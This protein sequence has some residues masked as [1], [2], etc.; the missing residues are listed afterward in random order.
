MDHV[1]IDNDVMLD[2]LLNRQPFSDDAAKIYELCKTGVI[3]GYTSPVILSNAHYVLR[4]IHSHENIVKSF[5]KLL[6]VIDLVEINKI[7]VID[8]LNSSFKDFEDALQNFAAAA[9]K[10]ISIVITR[11]FKDYKSSR[12]SIQTPLT[13][14]K[15]RP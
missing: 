6:E 3:K 14:L 11:N 2:F 10:D 4:K 7:T 12:L 9:N 1:L 15:Q 8:A 5:L 13:Y